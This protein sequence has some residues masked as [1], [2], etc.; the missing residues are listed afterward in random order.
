M[1]STVAES[2]C[3]SHPDLVADSISDA[4]LQEFYSKDPEAH[5]ACETLVTENTVILAGEI[6]STAAVDVEHTVRETIK[7][8]GYTAEDQGFCFSSCLIKNLLHEQSSDIDLGVTTEDPTKAGAG[9][10]GFMTG[11][12]CNETP[13]CMPLVLMA[14][15]FL[16]KRLDAIVTS[17]EDTT[18]LPDGKAQVIIDWEG[19]QPKLRTI[20]VSN[21]HKDVPIEDVRAEIMEKVVGP[22]AIEYFNGDLSEVEILINPTGRFLIGGPKGDTGLTGRKLAVENYGSYC[23]I[24]GGASAGKDLSKVDR[25]GAYM[26]RYIAKNVVAAG[27]AEECSVTLSYAIGDP[28]AKSITIQTDNYGLDENK[29]VEWFMEKLDISPYAIRKWIQSEGIDFN[30][31]RA[32][33]AYGND[34]FPWEQLNLVE[35]LQEAFTRIF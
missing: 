13:V 28:N 31:V 2:V 9:D 6:K 22:M 4:I 5:V 24:G 20:I 32:E 7:R 15:R 27:L 12:A 29:L 16:T 19:R 30:Q 3:Q 10:Q 23:C 1:V 35:D 33:G 25:S 21:H 34:I 18:L 11:Y 17:N 14:A 26:A 8:L